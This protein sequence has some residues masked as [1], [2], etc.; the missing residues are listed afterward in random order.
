MDKVVS[1][2]NN[3][4]NTSDDGKTINGGVFFEGVVGH[5]SI[6]SMNM[7]ISDLNGEELSNYSI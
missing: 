1:I 3:Y 7:D 5:G 6:S 2:D 4:Y